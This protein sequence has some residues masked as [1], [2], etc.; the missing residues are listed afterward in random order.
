MGVAYGLLV[1]KEEFS[2]VVEREVSFRRLGGV[3]DHTSGEGLLVGLS[4][5]DLLL[6]GTLQSDGRQ[7]REGEGE[8][9]SNK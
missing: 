8:Q 2:Q 6:D 5:K 4:L 1:E 3:V 7:V 9:V